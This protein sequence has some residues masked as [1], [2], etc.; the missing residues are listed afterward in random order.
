M[1]PIIQYKALLGNLK[2]DKEALIK[3]FNTQYALDDAKFAKIELN[4]I[5]VFEKI[6]QNWREHLSECEAYGDIEGAHIEHLKLNQAA[7]LK[8]AFVTLLK[9]E[10]HE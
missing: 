6:P 8:D 9:E 4:I 3:Q 10:A 2:K 1:T 7:A 5:D